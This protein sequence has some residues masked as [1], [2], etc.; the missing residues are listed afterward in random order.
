[1]A[2]E[3]LEDGKKRGLFVEG[4][5]GALI[6]NMGGDKV[7][8][9]IQK[10]DGTTLYLTRDVATVKYRVETWHPASILYVVDVAQSL[11]FEQDFAISKAL[12]YVEDSK[13]E[14]ISFGRMS[15]ADA[16]MSSR[17]G[18]V[19]LVDDLLEEAVKR[20]GVLS[21]AKAGE[22]PREEL[23]RVKE[24]V[25]I[26]S[27]K[28]GIFLQDRVKNLIFDWDKMITLE[29]NSAPYLCILMHVQIRFSK[30]RVWN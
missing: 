10:S 28:Y 22:M 21:A 8:A 2:D 18:N 9:L 25:G 12:G 27:I 24:I 14:H 7:P 15:F 30:R 6:Y 13:L 11:H 5:G 26:A 19:I 16:A 3:I 29:G 23:A 1:M 4:E 20:A 17:K